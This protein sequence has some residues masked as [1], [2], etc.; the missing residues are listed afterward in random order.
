MDGTAGE[1]IAIVARADVAGHPDAAASGPVASASTAVESTGSGTAVDGEIRRLL[2]ATDLTAV[3]E[4]AADA[5]I[6]LAVETGA[7]LVILSVIDPTRLRLPGGRFL[8]RIDQ[9]RSRIE[10]G[11][12]ELAGRARAAGAK[13]T[14][15]VWE[16]DPAEAIVAVCEAEGVDAVVLGSHGRGRL[17]RLVLGSISA[18]VT[19]Q[20][21]CRVIVVPA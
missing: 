20:A 1:A 3:S 21:A 12:H 4:R 9:E 15:L 5:A 16:G 18:R 6:R 13:A 19:D 8:R 11:A 7:E 10:A 17:G 14:Y 2:F